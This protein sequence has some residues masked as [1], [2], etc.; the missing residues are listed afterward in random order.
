LIFKPRPRARHAM[1][2]SAPAQ[3]SVHTLRATSDLFPIRRGAPPPLRGPAGRVWCEWH[4]THRRPL[5]PHVPNECISCA[6]ATERPARLHRS[7]PELE[8]SWRLPISAG[9]VEVDTRLTRASSF[10]DGCIYRVAVASPL[11]TIARQT[12]ISAHHIGFGGVIFV[13]RTF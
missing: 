3:P 11:T 13:P 4:T 7:R 6:A 1:R 2:A 12:P 5:Q 8:R 10:R 9:R